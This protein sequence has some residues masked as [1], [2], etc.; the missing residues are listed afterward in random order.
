MKGA[1][2]TAVILSASIIFSGCA[3]RQKTLQV[4]SDSIKNLTVTSHMEEPI[5]GDKSIIYC[6]TFQLAWNELKDNI[7]KGDIKLSGSEPE[8]VKYL[9]KSLST[10]KDISG[11]DYVAMVGFGKDDIVKKINDELKSK[12]KDQAPT[13]AEQL[14]K[15]DIFAYAFLYKNLKF[16]NEFE[17][18]KR[19]ISFNGS[20][21]AKEVKGFGIREYK[22]SDRASKVA[23]Q[24]TI[25]DYKNEDDFIIKLKSNSPKDEIILAKL[26]PEQS[27]L[28][29]IKAV[30]ERTKTSKVAYISGH[31]T[32]QIPCFDFNINHN[33]NELLK[34]PLQN[35]GFQ[36]YEI[37]K[38]SQNILFKFNETGATLKSEAG[39]KGTKS[40]PAVHHSLIF[41][42]PFLLMLK[43]KDAAYPY[44][45]IWV[46]NTEVLG[47]N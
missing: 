46:Q 22:D 23:E 16:E 41:N 30:E 35:S 25:V 42:K 34:K 26:K 6:S 18:L 20:T 1:K 43:E 14:E 38:A 29:T 31:D 19:A 40:A 4:D 21:G 7:I 10:K 17:K 15:D 32:L 44:F 27:L 33:Y 8:M 45:A 24:V 47:N 13:V 12:F 28:E 9:N 5:K 37:V 3:S 11:K 2:I 36:D 39:I